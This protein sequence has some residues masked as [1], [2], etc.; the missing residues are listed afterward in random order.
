[1]RDVRCVLSGKVLW[2]HCFREKR[3]IVRDCSMA[4]PG[5]ARSLR[6]SLLYCLGVLV[7]RMH[8]TFLGC[9]CNRGFL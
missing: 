6:V 2:G 9:G 8:H 4:C 7:C 5:H 1:V 3:V